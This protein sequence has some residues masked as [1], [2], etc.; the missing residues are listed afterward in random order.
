ML[1]E[2]NRLTGMRALARKPLQELEREEEREPRREQPRNQVAYNQIS[3]STGD[4]ERQMDSK[5]QVSCQRISWPRSKERHFQP[6]YERIVGQ[7]YPHLGVTTGTQLVPDRCQGR[8]LAGTSAHALRVSLSQGPK[9]YLDLFEDQDP[10]C[11]NEGLLLHRVLP[12][13]RD[14]ALLWS[15]HFAGTLKQQNFDK[16]HCMPYS[17]SR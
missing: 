2:I 10:N 17:I 16:V 14:A 13:Q 7:T 3:F 8:I 1:T 6:G 5:S 15:D 4:Q 12:G 9:E 11:R